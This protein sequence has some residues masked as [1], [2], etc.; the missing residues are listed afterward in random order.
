MRESASCACDVA[1]QSGKN[2]RQRQTQSRWRPND[3]DGDDVSCALPWVMANVNVIET[4]N[5][6]DEEG[7]NEHRPYVYL[8]LS[9]RHC[10]CYLPRPFPSRRRLLVPVVFAD[11]PLRP[12]T[13]PP[14]E[15][16]VRR[17]CGD[18]SRC[19]SLQAR[20]RSQQ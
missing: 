5:V 15:A 1:T 20:P 7:K 2:R 8:C 10:P 19:V 18:S 16:V 14:R 4:E 12:Y 11:S 3:D 6:N 9:R 17:G 13:R